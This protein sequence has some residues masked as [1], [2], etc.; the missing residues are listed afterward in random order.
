VSAMLAYWRGLPANSRGILAMLAAAFGFSCM[1]VFVKIAGETLPTAQVVFFRC[2]FGL[3]FLAPA[4]HRIGWRKSFATDRPQ[5]HG[6]R[7]LVGLCAMGCFFYALARAP[8]AD[9]TALSFAK[10]LFVIGFAVLFLG[11][12]VRWRRWTATAVGF[13]GILIMIRPGG[14]GFDPDTLAALAGAACVAAAVILVKKMAATES[15]ITTLAWFAAVATA[16][17]AIPAALVWV[18]P[19][20]E[21]W[22]MGALIGLLGVVSQSCIIA[23]YRTGEASAVAPFDY[24]RILIAAVFGVILF[25]EWPDVWTLVGAAVVIASTVYIGQREARLRMSKKEAEALVRKV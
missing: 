13:L 4:L 20:P 16:A 12:V 5:L 15:H 14:E 22:L 9:V 10:P 19:T 17:T 6:L 18:P 11:E 8:L 25:N 24:S 2:V 3:L 21:L 1:A 23:S 7:A